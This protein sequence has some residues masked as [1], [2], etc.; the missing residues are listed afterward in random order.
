MPRAVGYAGIAYWYFLSCGVLTNR[1]PWRRLSGWD[2]C[3]L[4][5]GTKSRAPAV[6]ETVKICG[7]GNG[8]RDLIEQ[9]LLC[10]LVFDVK[11]SLDDSLSIGW[12]RICKQNVADSKCGFCISAF[13]AF[14][15][16]VHIC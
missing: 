3:H 14:C 9:K 1:H 12:E 7:G 2:G 11:E 13:R 10:A 4:G 16:V 5:V 8:M 6:L 15:L